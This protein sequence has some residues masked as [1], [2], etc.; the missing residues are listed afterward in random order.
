MDTS[1]FPSI[2]V[3][4]DESKAPADLGKVG[5]WT[6]CRQLGSGRYASVFSTKNLTNGAMEAVKIVSRK[7]L[8]SEADW[9]NLSNE[10]DALSKLGP[11]P[12]I[13]CLTGAFQSQ[14]NIY[15]FMDLAK[16]KELFTFIKLRQQNKSPAGVVSGDAKVSITQSLLSALA[17]CHRQGLCHRDLKPENVMVDQFFLAKLVDF[18]CACSRYELVDQNVGT[19]PFIAP[20][21]LAAVAKDGAPADMWSLGALLLEMKCGNHTLSNF[22]GWDKSLPATSECASLLGVL[23]ANPVEGVGKILAKLSMNPDDDQVWQMLAPEPSKRPCSDKE[24]KQ[25]GIRRRSCSD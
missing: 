24:Q 2:P 7:E 14:Q 19:I 8:T 25:W 13:P 6:I 15:F 20:E 17:H 9:V 3:M 5:D 1:R 4:D 10:Y 22:L 18:G 21:C 23:F 11:H 12:H 16:G